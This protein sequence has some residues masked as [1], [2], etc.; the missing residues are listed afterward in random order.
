MPAR[1]AR[2][3]ELVCILSPLSGRPS[4]PQ[5][6]D[7]VERKALTHLGCIMQR[8]GR[9]SIAFVTPISFPVPE[10][11]DTLELAR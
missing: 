6:N 5:T 4:S 7:N 9:S 11:R 8:H 3:P 10:A 2:T 1:Q